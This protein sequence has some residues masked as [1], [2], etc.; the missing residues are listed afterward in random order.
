M[1]CPLG[2]MYEAVDL[3]K[4]EKNRAF[5]ENQ[6]LCEELETLK[7]ELDEFKCIHKRLGSELLET[8]NLADQL[9]FKNCLLENEMIDKDE[10]IMKIQKLK[11]DV[12]GLK[13]CIEKLEFELV[14]SGMEITQLQEKGDAL[15]ACLQEKDVAIHQLETRVLNCTSVHTDWD[16]TRKLLNNKR[17]TLKELL[18][19]CQEELDQAV[20]KVYDTT[21]R[22]KQEERLANSLSD[23]ILPL[24]HYV[25]Q[26]QASLD[27]EKAKNKQ[28]MDEIECEQQKVEMLETENACLKD[29]INMNICTIDAR[30]R[31]LHTIR[32]HYEAVKHQYE[33]YEKSVKDLSEQI[34]GI[35]KTSPGRMS[36]SRRPSIGCMRTASSCSLPLILRPRTPLRVMMR[37]WTPCPKPERRCD[38]APDRRTR[39]QNN[40]CRED[41]KEHIEVRRCEIVPDRTNQQNKECKEDDKEDYVVPERTNKQ[42]NECKEDNEDQYVVRRCDIAQDRPNKENNE[43][44]E[45]MKDQFVRRCEITQDRSNKQNDGK[46]NRDNKENIRRCNVSI[47]KRPPK[48]NNP[49]QT[50][51]NEQCDEN[52][53]LKSCLKP[54]S[55]RITFDSSRI[56]FDSSRITLSDEDLLDRA[57]PLIQGEVKEGNKNMGKLFNGIP[58][59]KNIGKIFNGKQENKNNT[60]NGMPANKNTM[61]NG[62]PANKNTMLNG[63]PANKNTMLHGMPA[64]KNTLLNGM[65]ANKNTLDN[66]KPAKKNTLDNGKPAKKNTLDNGMPAN[67]N[68]GKMCNGNKDVG[69]GKPDKTSIRRCCMR[70]TENNM[71]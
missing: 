31:S 66:G 64:N 3:L 23:Q 7:S 2:E 12:E 9:K 24:R 49:K 63:M 69:M 70:S 36:R 22:L 47:V 59:N 42:S 41:N 8:R 18:E 10:E 43:C 38:T 67:K 51:T 1:D 52:K 33:D 26:A 27:N 35:R 68:M 15:E 45:D 55:S 20:M 30:Q 21:H 19:E 14:S 32:H 34:V 62:M 28:L 5:C 58:A 48:P 16:I 61:L 29:K 50:P 37:E 56:T 65:P 53:P 40:E 71:E 44:K 25:Q 17:A 57:S 39:K 11:R 6:R 54:D 13:S 46:D 4:S 60:G